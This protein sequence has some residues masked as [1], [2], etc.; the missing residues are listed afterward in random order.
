MWWC[1]RKLIIGEDN[2]YKG[3]TYERMLF[4]VCDKDCERYNKAMKNINNILTKIPMGWK[5]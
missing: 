1:C 4:E 2:K 5:D 3:M